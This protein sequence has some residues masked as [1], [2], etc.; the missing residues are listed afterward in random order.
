[1]RKAAVVAYFGGQT[2]TAKALGI[3]KSAVN[4]WEE[5]R[6]IPLNCAIKALERS[7][8]ELK[9]DLALYEGTPQKA[10]VD[11]GRCTARSRRYRHINA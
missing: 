3:T 4:Q 7:G 11:F 9:L 10:L 5:D 1:M 8:G 2:A 6:P